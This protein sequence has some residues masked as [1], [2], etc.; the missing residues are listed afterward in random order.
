MKSVSGKRV[1]IT[2]A[3]VIF[4]AVAAGCYWMYAN[5]LVAPRQP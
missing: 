5:Y 3:V 2:I 1:A 4:I